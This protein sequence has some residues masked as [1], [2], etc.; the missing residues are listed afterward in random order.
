MSGNFNNWNLG[1]KNYE[2][3]K[4]K[5]CRYFIRAEQIPGVVEFKFKRG[6]WETEEMV[7]NRESIPNR[8][9]EFGKQDTVYLKIHGWKDINPALK[10]KM[11]HFKVNVPPSTPHDASIYISGN[12]NN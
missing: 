12:V 10:S 4:D 11:I 2:L 8:T 1:G 7:P 6:S 9:F 3:F 5:L